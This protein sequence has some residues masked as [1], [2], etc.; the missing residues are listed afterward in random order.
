MFSY[1]SS[2]SHN[3]IFCHIMTNNVA[4]CL[5]VA[6]DRDSE[7]NGRIVYRLRTGSNTFS[8]DQNTGHYKYLGTAKYLIFH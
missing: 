8:I 2:E 1:I 6:T 7:Q 3:A 5:F 4:F